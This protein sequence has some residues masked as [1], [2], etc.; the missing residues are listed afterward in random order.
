MSR[1]RKR[2]VALKHHNFKTLRAYAEYFKNP[3]LAVRPSAMPVAQAGATLSTNLT[4]LT[5]PGQGN[6]QSALSNKTKP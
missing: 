4:T 6:C 2:I 3:L 1:N 5:S